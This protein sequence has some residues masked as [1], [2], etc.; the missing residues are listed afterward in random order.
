M[1]IASRSV[2]HTQPVIQALDALGQSCDV[3][4][5][6]NVTS[7]PTVH[8]VEEAAAI[9]RD[10]PA[11][12]IVAIGGGSI[13]D[14]AKAV[15]GYSQNTGPLTDYIEGVGPGRIMENAPLPLIA[16]PTTSGTGA[17]MTKNAVI[18]S[19]DPAH[20][21]KRSFRDERLIPRFAI[22]DLELTLSLPPQAT[23]YA[24]MDALTQLIE[25]YT[26]QKAQ[27]MTDALALSGIQACA[28]MLYRAYTQPN[29]LAARTA[30]AYGSMLSGLCLA[31]SGL[32]AVHGLAAAFGALYQVPHGMACAILLPHVIE[33]NAHS[34]ADKTVALHHA[35]TGQ[36]SSH[37][38]DD[39]SSIVA[40]IQE[41][42]Q[43]MSIPPDFKHLGLTS[44]D[45]EP[46]ISACSSSS[47]SGNP[48][49]LSHEE[50]S[51]LVH[52]LIV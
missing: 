45:I 12:L 52:K 39:A 15:A 27:P 13:I 18:S 37:S 35:L 23:A 48:R 43:Q 34:I 47:M 9:A 51:D 24:G 16:V 5:Y 38:C 28:P 44:D 31:N 1:V 46:L 40:F 22:I 41:L 50:L 32:G 36:Q 20:P 17:E 8:I 29:D 7:E 42:C 11:D 25:S 49:T 19:S 26:S 6:Q 33:L 21:F 14:T 10:W 30:M 3:I 4:L 2:L